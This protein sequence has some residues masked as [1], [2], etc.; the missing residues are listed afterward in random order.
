MR[1]QRL[2]LLTL[3][4]LA[5]LGAGAD[6]ELTTARQLLSN[7]QPLAAAELLDRL[8]EE[9]D[10]G[11]DARLLQGIVRAELGEI[12]IAR[13]TFGALAAERPERAEPRNNLAVLEAHE[14]EL[15]AAILRLEALLET[16]GLAET[17]RAAVAGNLAALRRAADGGPLDELALLAGDG[18][19]IALTAAPAGEMVR[20]EE[21]LPPPSE[22]R[23][24]TSRNPPP[25]DG[26]PRA[27]ALVEVAEPISSPEAAAQRPADAPPAHG[28]IEELLAAARDDAEPDA[29]SPPAHGSIEELLAA[30]QEAAATEKA[31]ASEPAA[32]ATLPAALSS[33]PALDEEE[34]DRRAV[35][36]TIDAW[37]KAWSA[38]RTDD[39]LAFYAGDYRPPGSDRAAWLALRRQRLERP[40]YIRVW[41]T[42]LRI[43]FPEPDLA[44]ARFTQHYESDRYHD[45]VQKTLELRREGDRWHIVKEAVT[46]S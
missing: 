36:L 28:S 2:T 16:G 1:R 8:L 32:P 38:Q 14:G 15:A 26:E 37:A 44:V 46:G 43:A 19:T 42:G 7:G 3:C 34:A 30:A 13:R 4:S 40:R 10:A 20:V 22:A 6:D 11:Y 18:T 33:L 39:Y 9:R 45:V 17:A 25:A 41:I 27:L 31:A 12:S 29:A 5:L 24:A 23:P 21:P 35:R